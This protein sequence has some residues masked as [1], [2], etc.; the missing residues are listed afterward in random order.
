MA[1]AGRRFLR[2]AEDEEGGATEEAETTSNLQA[3]AEDHSSQPDAQMEESEAERQPVKA[4]EA[5]QQEGQEEDDD[6]DEHHYHRHDRR[7]QHH[8][9]GQVLLEEEGSGGGYGNLPMVLEQVDHEEDMEVLSSV[10]QGARPRKQRVAV[11][12]D[13]LCKRCVAGKVFRGCILL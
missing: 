9:E 10:S 4:R 1:A 6:D 12:L 3:D 5:S 7:H 2:H 8:Q 13:R 11:T